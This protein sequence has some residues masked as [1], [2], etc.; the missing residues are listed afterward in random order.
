MDFTWANLFLVLLAAWVAGTAVSK[1]GFPSVLGELG[2]GILLGPPL[3]GLIHGDS[4]ITVLGRVG[5]LMMILYIGTRVDPREL[6]KS[7]AS[8]VLPTIGGFFVPFILGT[9]AM[10]TLFDASL[11]TGLLVGTVMATTALVTVSRVLVDLKLLE[12]RL[13]QTLLTASL[14]SIILVLIAF[15]SVQGIAKA[16]TVRVEDILLVLGKAVGF[17][18][19]ISALGTYF[20]PIIGKIHAYL[21]HMPGRTSELTFA[22]LIALATV[23]GAETFGLSFILGG[24]AAGVFLR[25]EMF[26]KDTYQDI[27]MVVRDVAL[28]FLAPIFYVS[29]GFNVNF[30]VFTSNPALVVTVVTV[31]LIG[32]FLGGSLFYLMTGRS[33]REAIV[34]GLGMNARGSIDIIV[35]G[36]GLQLGIITQDLFTSLIVS[37]FIGTLSVPLLLKLGVDWLKRSGDLIDAGEC[38]SHVAK[39]EHRPA[40]AS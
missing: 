31:S 4:G 39:T 2:V 18:A 15:S 37:I 29:A 36:V 22:L 28:G 16:G 21:P 6:I 25:P 32:K 30:S 40:T 12:T 17:L 19:L 11:P 38:D 34:I 27:F 24:F 9:L 8:A 23:I 13:G 20:F 33:W 35:A 3:L 7:A 5:I 14:F 10:M 1:L 26:E